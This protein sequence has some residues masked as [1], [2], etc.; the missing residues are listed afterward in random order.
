MIDSFTHAPI[1]GAVVAL[2]VG[3]REIARAVTGLDGA[4]MLSGD[5]RHLYLRTTA[6]GYS[7]GHTPVADLDRRE[8]V[9]LRRGTTIA[10]SVYDPMTRKPIA[11]AKVSCLRGLTR[12]TDTVTTDETGA[13]KIEH[14]VRSIAIRAEGYAWDTVMFGG[15]T[16]GEV[17]RAS[18]GLVPPVP[19]TGKVLDENGAPAAGAHVLAFISGINPYLGATGWTTA[20]A[21]GTFAMPLAGGSKLRVMAFRDTGPVAVEELTLDGPTELELS[22][23]RGASFKGKVVT[24]TGKPAAGARVLASWFLEDRVAR[25]FDSLRGTYLQDLGWD[26][27]VGKAIAVTD[28]S[29]EFE[30]DGMWVDGLFFRVNHPDLGRTTAKAHTGSSMTLVLST[31]GVLSATLVDTAGNLVD[32]DGDM[33]FIYMGKPS[34]GKHQGWVEPN[35][36]RRGRIRMSGLT[37]GEWMVNWEYSDKRV[38]LEHKQVKIRNEE[39]TEVTWMV[40]RNGRVFGRT[41]DRR[42]YPVSNT[43]VSSSFVAPPSKASMFGF[44]G[45]TQ[46]V[47]TDSLG[48]FRVE[49]VRGKVTVEFDRRS[50]DRAWPYA[51]RDIEIEVASG[52][53]VDMGDVVLDYSTAPR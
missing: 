15:V 7:E 24:A 9:E 31:G 14:C 52:S 38:Q 27:N 2:R 22:L 10:G 53:E 26:W 32:I 3:E 8:S 17:L 44:R 1:Q 21:D 46:C 39:V 34:H 47:A 51:K 49:G 41:V 23:A 13:F 48:R 30:F 11:G 28:A 45:G 4:F 16:D 5:G 50:D 35:A 43:C 29:G 25:Y 20:G 37:P 6:P 19:V 18:P 33:G 36:L 42:G 40:D 12:L